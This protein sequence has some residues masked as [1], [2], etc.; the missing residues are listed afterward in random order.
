MTTGPSPSNRQAL[1]FVLFF[2]SD[3]LPLENMPAKGHSY[4]PCIA[5]GNPACSTKRDCSFIDGGYLELMIDIGRASPDLKT[6][7]HGSRSRLPKSYSKSRP[8]CCGVNEVETISY[9]RRSLLID[10]RQ[11]IFYLYF[12]LKVKEALCQK[13]AQSGK[14]HCL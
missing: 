4:K 12:N 14:L 13:S 6:G 7:C 9:Y 1:S 5:V 8:L 11:R 3:C 2:V 10:N